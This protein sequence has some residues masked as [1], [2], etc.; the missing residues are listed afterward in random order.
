MRRAVQRGF[1]SGSKR[2]P[3]PRAGYGRF[4]GVLASRAAAFRDHRHVVDRIAS[5]DLNN[6]I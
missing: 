5:V 6:T 1:E 3:M 2:E 4:S